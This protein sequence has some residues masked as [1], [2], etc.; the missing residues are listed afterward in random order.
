MA[1]ND[2]FAVNGDCPQFDVEAIAVLYVSFLRWDL[3]D[4]YVPTAE[5]DNCPLAGGSKDQLLL[6]V[7]AKRS[8]AFGPNRISSR[9]GQIE[10]VRG[11]TAFAISH[12]P[13]N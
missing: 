13:T 10:G 1:A 6:V 9:P 11:A 5:V 3:I 2:E 7:N 4:R 8:I 12:C